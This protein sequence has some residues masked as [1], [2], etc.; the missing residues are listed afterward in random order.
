MV[1]LMALKL[2][3]EFARRAR[4]EAQAAGLDLEWVIGRMQAGRTLPQIALEEQAAQDT[5]YEG[6]TFRKAA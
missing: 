4:R 2:E 3:L 6:G 1:D 5:A